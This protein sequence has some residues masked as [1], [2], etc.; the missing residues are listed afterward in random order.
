VV[1][2]M[3]RGYKKHGRGNKCTEMFVG[4]PLKRPA[5]ILIRKG[6]KSHMKD[7]YFL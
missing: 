1:D 3:H 7:G 5:G 2:G 4:K 6:G